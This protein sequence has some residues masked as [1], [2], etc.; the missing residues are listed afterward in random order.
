[1]LIAMPGCSPMIVDSV[2]PASAAPPPP[3][4][5]ISDRS[6]RSAA[7]SAVAI[8][9]MLAGA[10]RA[11]AFDSYSTPPHGSSR[12]ATA[13]PV[14]WTGTVSCAASRATWAPAQVAPAQN[15][16]ERT[17]VSQPFPSHFVLP[18]KNAPP[19]SGRREFSATAPTT[20]MSGSTSHQPRGRGR[21][22]RDGYPYRGVGIDA[23]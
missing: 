7:T 6:V 20:S 10:I 1:M 9:V 14:I 22:L 8:L 16:T 5:T 4:P 19:P 2:S 11:P 18:V 23:I 12:T 13:R 15:G 17:A 21:L 3:P